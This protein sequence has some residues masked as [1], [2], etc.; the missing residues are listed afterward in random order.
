ME[1]TQPEPRRTQA[2]RSATTRAKILAAVVQCVDDQGLSRTTSQRIARTAGVTV[3][4]VQHHFPSKVDILA[5]ALE[6]SF[7][8]LSAA[9]EGAALADSSVEERVSVFVDRAWAHYGSAPG[10]STL[11]IIMATRDAGAE[12]GA[13]AANWADRPIAESSRRARGLWDTFFAS[14]PI[15]PR[16]HADLLRFTFVTLS[17]MAMTSR[18]TT[19]PRSADRQVQLLKT[20]LAALIRA[21]LEPA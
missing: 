13:T 4:A 6:D 19:P 8:R 2:E 12:P 7:E 1:R 5:A 18:F 14:L 20:A 16:R 17:G 15:P 11:E 9:F 3:G 21:E 10:R